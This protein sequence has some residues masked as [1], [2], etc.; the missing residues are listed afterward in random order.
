MQFYL[1]YL[2]CTLSDKN[3]TKM[4]TLTHPSQG[5][6]QREHLG[7]DNVEQRF[8]SKETTWRQRPLTFRSEV[9]WAN[10]YTVPPLIISDGCLKINSTFIERCHN[11]KIIQLKYKTKNNSCPVKSDAFVIIYMHINSLCEYIEI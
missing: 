9:R 11:N 5:Y 6:A 2:H 1:I 3:I 7:E 8:L 10:L 4:I